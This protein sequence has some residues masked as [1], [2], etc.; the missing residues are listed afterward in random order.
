MYLKTE[1]GVV[2]EYPYRFTKVFE[3]NPNTSFPRLLAPEVL[4]EYGIYE[5]ISS[6]HP[7]IDRFTQ[8]YRE[9]TPI[10]DEALQGYKQVFVVEP[11]TTEKYKIEV[12][13]AISE[14]ESQITQR[15]LREALLG[16]DNG[17]LASQDQQIANLRSQLG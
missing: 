13:L 4:V 17:W 10:W 9:D 2:T 14:L 11:I 12:K 5:V 6:E 7:T 15:R 16:S 3:D 8:T 1:N